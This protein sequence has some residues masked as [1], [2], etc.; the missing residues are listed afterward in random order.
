[1]PRGDYQ[2]LSLGN[3]KVPVI[4][5]INLIRSKLA[6]PYKRELLVAHLKREYNTGPESLISSGIITHFGMNHYKLQADHSQVLNILRKWTDRVDSPEI[7]VS[8]CKNLMDSI[9]SSHSTPKGIDYIAV[10]SDLRMIVFEEM[11]CELQC[12]DL[13][14]VEPK[15]FFINIYN[16][17]VLH[18]KSRSG[19][20][21]TNIARLLYFDR[22]KYNV[23]GHIFSLNDIENGVLR[24]HS[25]PLYHF[26]QCL[27]PVKV[28]L[29]FRVHFALNCGAKSCPSVQHFTS[30]GIDEELRI[31]TKAFL[32]DNFIIDGSTITLSKIVGWYAS[33][34]GKT[35]KDILVAMKTFV[36]ASKIVQLENITNPKLVYSVYDWSD[37][38]AKS[39]TYRPI[40][41]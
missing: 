29:D 13:N 22:I 20:P 12:I 21:R 8:M 39:M 7:T 27:T 25:R 24:S 10:R 18:S 3:L 6:S 41:G 31:V 35:K 16:L 9:I 15:S 4:T 14:Q 38:S 37:D 32:E 2:D 40:I 28:P 33:D 1:M 11:I 30:I 34:F 36:S 26:R 17:L 5:F 23:G 19:I